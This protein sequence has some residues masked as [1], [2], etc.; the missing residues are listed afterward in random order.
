[1]DHERRVASFALGAGAVGAALG[2]ANV[3]RRRPAW[4]PPARGT[5]RAGQ[6]EVTTSG[7]GAPL[8]LLHG[9]VGSGRFWGAEYDG[10]AV[11]H[12]LVV[13]DLLGFG[14]S[15]RPATG[16]GPDEHADAV[17]N[18]LHHLGVDQPVI[19]GAHSLGTVIA[20]RLAARHP[21]LVA[22]VTA[23]GPPLY[24]DRAGAK[25]RIG[26]ASPMAKVF[27]LPGSL[28]ERSCR[29]VCEH[30][31]AAALVARWSHPG[32]PP[33]L[34]ADAVQHTWHSYSETL[35]RCLLTGAPAT[36][37]DEIAVPVR[38]IAGT[39]DGV[40]DLDF[41]DELARRHATTLHVERWEGDHRL[42]LTDARHCIDAILR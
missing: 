34:A 35:D 7:T 2:Y 8:V 5:Q 32:L 10:L 24:R 30:R 6:L 4:R 40:V 41:L 15:E 18:A 9:L 31:G 38:L 14:R 11:E 29:W 16:Y 22:Q 26:A 42:P 37:L 36:W 13:P 3:R 33:E 39:H 20:L 19:I 28:A 21:D 27:V 17:A 23:F 25:R 12:R 1:M